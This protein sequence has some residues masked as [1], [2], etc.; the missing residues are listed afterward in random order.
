[1]F[2]QAPQIDL[3]QHSKPFFLIPLRR[4]F[5]DVSQHIDYAIVWIGGVRFP[6]GTKLFLF[7]TASALSL[8]STRPRASWPLQTAR[9]RVKQP[10]READN[11]PPAKCWNWDRMLLRLFISPLPKYVS[12]ARSGASS[13]EQTRSR[14]VVF[15]PETVGLCLKT[16]IGR[17]ILTNGVITT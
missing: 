17:N 15:H 10:E 7:A 5:R 11:L 9:P 6:S 1:M 12:V 4:L 14:F 3:Y 8:E 13:L 16:V 2:N